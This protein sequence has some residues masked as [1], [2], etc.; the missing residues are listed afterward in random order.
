MLDWRRP[1]CAVT[2]CRYREFTLS[3]EHTLISQIQG[4][5]SDT[6]THP[7][8]TSCRY[9]EFTLTLEHTLIYQIQGVYSDTRTH[10]NISDTGSLL[11]H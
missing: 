10:P 2:S 1:G 5:Y 11:C 8:V 9:R 7:A 4:V 3:L 6:R